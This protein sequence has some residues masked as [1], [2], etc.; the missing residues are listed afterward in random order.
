MGASISQMHSND[1]THNTCPLKNI[2]IGT[3]DNMNVK[4][5]STGPQRNLLELHSQCTKQIS[6]F[7]N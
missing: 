4:N 2:N 3:I 1:N 7:D 6:Y 5:N